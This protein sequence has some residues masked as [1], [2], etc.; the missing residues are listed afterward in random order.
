MSDRKYQVGPLAGFA[1]KAED[2]HTRI[3]RGPDLTVI[4]GDQE[5]HERLREIAIKAD[6]QLKRRD[7]VV[8]M[9]ELSDIIEEASQ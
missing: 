3:T 7:R 1:P 8:S 9:D 2:G 5:Q 4:G 6:E